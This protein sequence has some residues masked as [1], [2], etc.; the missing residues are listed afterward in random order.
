MELESIIEASY[1]RTVEMQGPLKVSPA[2][3]HRVSSTS[4]LAGSLYVPGYFLFCLV[5]HLH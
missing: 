3:F 1:L 5:S 4:P 2:T